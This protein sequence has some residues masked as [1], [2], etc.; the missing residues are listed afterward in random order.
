MT[1]RLQKILAS[2]GVGSRRKAEEMITAGRVTCNGRVCLLGESA[3]PDIDIILLDGKPI[4]SGDEYTYIMLHKPRGFVT[5][6]SDEKGRRNV[7]ELVK[8]CGKRVYPVGRLDM[9]S[10]GLLILTNDGDFANHLMHPKH[11]VDK[12]YMV[13]VVGYS[14]TGLAQLAQPITLDGYT[15]KKP[16]V[17]LISADEKGSAK[18]EVVIHEGRNRQVRRMCAAAGMQ[19]VRL[20]RISEGNLQLGDLPLGKWRKLTDREV[21]SLKE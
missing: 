4:P 21:E 17:K 20:V 14:E 5:T 1:Q 8:D 2:R 15:I 7:A 6:L 9:D 11:N 16:S 13:T 10:E 18:L 3:D 12:T 19:V